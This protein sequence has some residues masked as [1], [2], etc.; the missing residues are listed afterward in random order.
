LA[1][2]N[3]ADIDA[4]TTIGIRLTGSVT[5]ETASLNELARVVD[6]RYRM[7]GRQSNELTASS[8][9]KW[10]SG[11][12][13]RARSSCGHCCERGT[14]FTFASGFHD[15]NFS[16]KQTSRLLNISQFR[17]EIT[18]V[19]VQQRGNTSGLRGHLEQEFQTFCIQRCAGKGHPSNVT[20]WPVEA[21]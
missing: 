11:H 19:W 5:H 18:S 4:G 2:K 1:L 14:E 20:T 8:Q 3:P 15:Y 17:L 6:C 9:Q 13:Q 12:E 21:S 10:T 7:P 16:S